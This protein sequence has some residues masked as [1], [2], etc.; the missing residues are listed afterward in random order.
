[1]TH[2]RISSVYD[3]QR[4]GRD[5]IIS[6]FAMTFLMAC[7]AVATV[8]LWLDLI[9]GAALAM[10]V[11]QLFRLWRRFHSVLSWDQETV[12]LQVEGREVA[13]IDWS[14]LAD[15]NLRY[16]STRRDRSSGWFVLALKDNAGHGFSVDTDL[17]DFDRFLTF[18]WAKARTH[19]LTPN[20]AT[21][22]NLKALG[23]ISETE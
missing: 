3:R 20:R 1:M 8:G 13:V 2:A 21:L 7:M 14:K 19:G 5:V 16:Y 12:E 18:A 9:L 4:I 23:L 10:F 15:F 17:R 11:V 6:V 22:A